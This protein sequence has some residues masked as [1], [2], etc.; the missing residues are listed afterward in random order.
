VP[1]WEFL[2][3]TNQDIS[4]S[5]EIWDFFARNPHPGTVPVCHAPPGNPANVRT[6]TVSINALPAHLAHGDTEGPCED[7]S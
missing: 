2:G 5:A 1:G 4:A 6:I 3:P 7:V